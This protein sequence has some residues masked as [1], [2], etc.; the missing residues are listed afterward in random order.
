MF[1]FSPQEP[2]KNR[3]VKMFS[4]EEIEPQ[5]IFLD[6]LAKKREEELDISEKK[7]EVPLSRKIIQRFYF[8]FLF[9]ILIFLAQTFYFQIIKSKDLSL[10]AE[11]NK[12]RIFLI[13]P[14]RGVIYDNKER[15]LVFNQ[16]SFDL[17]CDK[18][19]FP[20]SEGEKLR[21]LE[22]LSQII[23]KDVEELRKQIEESDLVEVLVLE[24]LDQETLILLETNPLFSGKK[25]HPVCRVEMN[26]VRN[27]V[28]G[29][30]FAHLLG[31]VGKINQEEIKSS[32]DYSISDYIGKIGLEKSYEKPLRGTPGKREIERDALGQI[33]SEKL[34][35]E[36]ESG[37]SLVLWLDS[38][39]QEKIEKELSF[40]LKNT[41]AKAGVG[42]A[43]N[44]KTGG[45]LSLVSLPSF[46]NNLFSQGQN[47]EALKNLLID[48][49]EPLFNRVI[50]GEY[51]TGS[52][53]KPLIAS[54]ALQEKVISPEKKI[55][56]KGFIE[57]P[58]EYNPEIIYT[59]LD[60]KAHDWTDLRKAIA[61]SCNVYFYTV[62]GGYQDQKGL[63][64]DRIKK[65]LELFG[66]G[67]ITGI[68]LPEEK[69]GLIPD[70]SWK[71]ETIGEGW[72]IGN[73]YH[74]SIG[75]GYLR[76]APL[77]VATAFAA[78]ANGGKL[79]QPQ[80]VQKIVNSEKNTIEEIEPI[81]IRGN[82]ID[83]E[84]LQIV[85]EG[86]REAVAYGSSV[87]LNDLPVKAAA[88]TGTAETGREGYYHNWV[89]V[90]APYEDPQ[91]VL[92]IMIENVREGMAVALPVAKAVLEWYFG[93]GR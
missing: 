6:N 57:V 71:K 86:M 68:D 7:F 35:S 91:I 75:Q 76:I 5:E 25:E 38:D 49:K 85:R 55:Y 44:P 73:T 79:F 13:R 72:Y 2:F 80:V 92:T 39:L 15:Q 87:I 21:I 62:G 43:L 19:D 42:V 60:W 56:G 90:F 66:W 23:K 26:T 4:R 50:S 63:G 10:L 32:I 36:P 84:N 34:I 28:S 64:P 14:E 83:A 20:W 3:K 65:Y 33:K 45:V 40:R 59:F 77:Q 54:A 69:S 11:G 12:T 61:V 17:V 70:P 93:A 37:K 67:K 1:P 58:H 82:F 78:I 30:S 88:K 53:I 9:L 8:A 89:T 81:I 29:D 46:D 51:P 47:P 18:R 16:P 24:N 27:Y 52:T 48:E 41:G 74:L 31:Y 22:E